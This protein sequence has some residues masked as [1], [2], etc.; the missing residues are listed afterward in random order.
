MPDRR[1]PR[2]VDNPMAD[3]QL[4]SGGLATCDAGGGFTPNKG[5][6]ATARTFSACVCC[7]C[8]A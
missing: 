3:L 5:K 2:A 8:T 6:A 7:A 1:C 4:V